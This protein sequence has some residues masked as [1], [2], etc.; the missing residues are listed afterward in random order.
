MS[1]LI[2]L[3]FLTGAVLGMRFKVFVL[4]PAFVFAAIAV[5]AAGIVRGDSLRAMLVAG[6]L[7]LIS[8]QIGYL[9]GILT[10]YAVTLAR[11]GSRRKTSLQAQS[12]R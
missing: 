10:R 7:A 2:L 1:I 3:A 12:I 8:L 9:G 5:F 11:A 6:M 4:A